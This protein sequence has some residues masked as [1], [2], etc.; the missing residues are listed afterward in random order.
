[1]RSERREAKPYRSLAM[2]PQR[3]SPADVWRPPSSTLAQLTSSSIML[4]HARILPLLVILS[5]QPTILVCR[6]LLGFLHACIML[7][8]MHRRLHM[9]WHDSQDHIKAVGCHAGCA[10]YCTLPAH[11]GELACA[12][13]CNA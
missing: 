4:V 9:G 13:S 2:S 8:W 11:S 10:L 12:W 3:T 5:S 1:M 6:V 7:R